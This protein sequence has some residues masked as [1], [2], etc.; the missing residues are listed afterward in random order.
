M[1][2]RKKVDIPQNALLTGLYWLFVILTHPCWCLHTD[3]L[4]AYAERAPSYLEKEEPNI[5]LN[6]HIIYTQP[7]Y[8]YW[9]K[10][11]RNT[12][13]LK[14]NYKETRWKAYIPVTPK[15]NSQQELQLPPLTRLHHNKTLRSTKIHKDTKLATVGPC[16]VK[17][18][19]HGITVLITLKMVKTCIHI[20]VGSFLNMTSMPVSQPCSF[21]ASWLLRR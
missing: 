16:I 7:Q 3:T 11:W 2:V 13:I 21:I 8:S 19:G 9:T 12:Q 17:K 5:K 6:K 15:S 18:K 4:L 20:C 10:Q 14:H 1:E